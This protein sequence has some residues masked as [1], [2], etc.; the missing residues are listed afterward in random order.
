M[1]ALGA[2]LGNRARAL[3]SAIALLARWMTDMRCSDVYATAPQYIEDQP[4]FLN[5]AVCG[6]TLLS[7]FEVLDLA[8]NAERSL[9]RERTQRY[10]P[11]TIDID[12][13]YYGSWRVETPLLTIPHPLRMERRFVMAPVAD[14]VPD[15]IDP[16]TGETVRAMLDHLP[17][18]P[19]DC[20]SLGPLEAV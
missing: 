13:V 15:L 11:R 19:G 2:N 6:M 1:L 5:M 20:A 14:L 8:Q 9:G 7:P 10:G 3:R 12:I 18:E 4:A 17:S 16:V